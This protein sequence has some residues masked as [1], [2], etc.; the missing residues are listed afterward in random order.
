[1]STEDNKRVATEFFARFSA[2]DIQ[3]V[4]LRRQ[5]YRNCAKDR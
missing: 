3:P 1:M 5:I 2:K 4:A